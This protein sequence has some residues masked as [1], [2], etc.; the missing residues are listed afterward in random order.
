MQKN[1]NEKQVWVNS[2]C[3]PKGRQYSGGSIHSRSGR[4]VNAKEI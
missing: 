2:E 4:V 1:K 3:P